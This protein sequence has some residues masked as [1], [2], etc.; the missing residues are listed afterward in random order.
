MSFRWSFRSSAVMSGI[1]PAPPRSTRTVESAC[2]ASRRPRTRARGISTLLGADL[3]LLPPQFWGCR[4]MQARIRRARAAKPAGALSVGARRSAVAQERRDVDL[5]VGDLERRAL[6]ARAAVAAAGAVA[7]LLARGARA[8]TAVVE[9][10]GDDRHA[11]LVAH[12]LVDHRAEDDVRGR[13]GRALDD[14]GRL[15]DLEQ[16]DVA[17]AGDVEQDAGRALDG[18]LEQRA[19]DRLLRRLGRAVLTARLADA[20][21][22]RSGVGHDRPDVGEVEVDETGD[23]DEVGDALDALAQDVVGLAER[24]EDRRAALDDVEQL[25]VRDDDERVD[26]LAQ[27]RDALV[28]LA[29]PLRALE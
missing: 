3:Y 13:V 8:R 20:H 21:Q 29:H 5:V 27:A 15:V 23:R 1:G 7:R 16:A 2:L 14:L 22:G 12:V 24:L 9:A 11:D 6:D 10:G 19:R 28:R 4:G 18:L 17:A 25:L 26:D